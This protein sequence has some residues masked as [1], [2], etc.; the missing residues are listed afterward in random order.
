MS[1][2]SKRQ[3]KNDRTPWIIAFVFLAALTIFCELSV[4]GLCGGLGQAIR[5]GLH[6]TF[7]L[8]GWIF[9][10]LLWIWLFYIWRFCIV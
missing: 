9:P 8:L 4:F 1:S 5:R 6:G 3:K 2:R 7:G 10:V